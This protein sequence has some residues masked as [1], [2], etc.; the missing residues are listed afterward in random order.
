MKL[1]AN[2]QSWSS[3]EKEPIVDYMIYFKELAHGIVGWQ[4]QNLPDR[5][6]GWKQARTYA[7]ILSLKF[8]GQ[9]GRLEM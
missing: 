6:A 5:P 4:V 9:V 2:Y 7:A 3:S 8:V 1:K